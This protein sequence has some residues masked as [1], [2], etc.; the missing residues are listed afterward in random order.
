[1]DATGDLGA[2]SAERAGHVELM[3]RRDSTRTLTVMARYHLSEEGQ[4][5]SLLAG[6]D[7]RAVQDVTVSVP[8]NRFHLVSVDAEGAARLKLDPRYALNADQDVIRHDAPPTYDVPP[9]VDDLLKEA[10]RNHQ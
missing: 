1:M 7:G 2:P 5:A 3:P 4:K 6:G 8:M 9:S 10:A